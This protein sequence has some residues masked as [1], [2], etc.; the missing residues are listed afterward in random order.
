MDDGILVALCA[1]PLSSVLVHSLDGSPTSSMD[2]QCGQSCPEPAICVLDSWMTHTQE[3]GYIQPLNILK[4]S[5]IA[6]MSL[7]YFQQDP[8]LMQQQCK[9]LQLLGHCLGGIKIGCKYMCVLEIREAGDLE[10]LIW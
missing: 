2:L 3:S 7:V 9:F 6:R 10:I 1:M 4:A 8:S 5:Q